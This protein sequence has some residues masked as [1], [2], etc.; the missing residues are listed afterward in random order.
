MNVEMTGDF[1]I[2]PGGSLGPQIRTVLAAI[3]SQQGVDPSVAIGS[4]PSGQYN[5]NFPS[6]TGARGSIVFHLASKPSA[7]IYPFNAQSYSTT[8]NPASQF[9]FSL[10]EQIE[11]STQHRVTSYVRFLQYDIDQSYNYVIQS[12]QLIR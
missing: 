9:T 7:I 11:N 1:V 10:G 5:T 8:P 6:V 2:A 3:P 4:Q 12:P